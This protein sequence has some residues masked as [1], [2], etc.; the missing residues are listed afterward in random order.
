[1]GLIVGF[2]AYAVFVALVEIIYSTASII[3]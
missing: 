3:P 2:I 1:M